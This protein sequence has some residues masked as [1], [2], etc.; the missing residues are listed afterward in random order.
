MTKQQKWQ[1]KK[2]ALGLCTMCGQKSVNKNHCEYHRQRANQLAKQWY[3]KQ[4]GIK[5]ESIA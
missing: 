4:M 3:K 5:K 2:K 1:I